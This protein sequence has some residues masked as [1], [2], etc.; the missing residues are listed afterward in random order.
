MDKKSVAGSGSDVAGDAGLGLV[1]LAVSPPFGRGL[2][3]YSVLIWVLKV[4]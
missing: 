4:F 2:A 3:T 1:F